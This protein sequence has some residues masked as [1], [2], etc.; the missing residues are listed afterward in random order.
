MVEHYLFSI[1]FGDGTSSV[2]TYVLCNGDHNKA[3]ARSID[4]MMRTLEKEK[5]DVVMPIA[6][7]TCVTTE[8]GRA[9]IH[10]ELLKMPEPRKYLAKA[11]AF[12]DRQKDQNFYCLWIGVGSSNKAML[13]TIH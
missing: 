6:L 8:A 10:K 3:L 11:L 1:Q 13:D 5:I 9:M 4:L 2:N 7:S 12:K